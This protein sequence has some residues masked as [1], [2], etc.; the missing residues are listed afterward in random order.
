M[1]VRRLNQDASH[2]LRCDFSHHGSSQYTEPCHHQYHPPLRK[3]LGGHYY[4]GATHTYAITQ[5][6]SELGPGPILVPLG[7]CPQLQEQPHS[8]PY[9]ASPP[10]CGFVPQDQIQ[11]QPRSNLVADAAP[12]KED[13]DD[14]EDEDAPIPLQNKDL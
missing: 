14:D 10:H 13:G 5:G 7:V 1:D 2:P 12:A 3:S 8:P 11:R 4:H 9:E 6:E